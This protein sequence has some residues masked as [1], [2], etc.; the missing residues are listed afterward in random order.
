MC[1]LNHKMSLEGFQKG[2]TWSVQILGV[3]DN[4]AESEFFI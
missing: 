1:L 4:T 3:D 2:D